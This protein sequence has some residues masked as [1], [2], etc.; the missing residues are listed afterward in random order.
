MEIRIAQEA[1]LVQIVEIYNQAIALRSATADL[2]PVEPSDK[3]QWLEEHVPE[4]H[5]VYVAK[6]DDKIVGWCS[7]SP[8][9]R[10]RMA[11]RYTAEISYYVHEGYRRMGIGSA[12]A[13]H[14]ISQ[15]ETLDIKTLFALLL[16][17]NV[18]S[19]QLLEK[20]GFAKWGHLPNVADFDGQE[21]GHL[22]YGLRVR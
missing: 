22:I 19:V 15:C 16:D 17:V 4:K 11:L 21:C 10:G 3:Q 5:P 20:L 8:Y 9:R 2:T 6:V 1:D 12:L 18:A 13:K 14:A 7:L